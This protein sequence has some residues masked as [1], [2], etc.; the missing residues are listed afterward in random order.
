MFYLSLRPFPCAR[1]VCGTRTSRKLFGGTTVSFNVF[2]CAGRKNRRGSCGE[3]RERQLGEL[4]EDDGSYVTISAMKEKPVPTKHTQP[5][6]GEA[7]KE[8][9]RERPRSRGAR[10]GS[11]SGRSSSATRRTFD[12][13][14]EKARRCGAGTWA[15]GL[16]PKNR[17]LGQKPP[18]SA[19][20]QRYR[21]GCLSSTDHD[22]PRLSSGIG[23]PQRQVPC[24]VRM[25]SGVRVPA[26]AL[27]KT[28][29]QTFGA[30]FL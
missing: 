23:G 26:S 8:D 20:L 10:R 11:G 7:S 29:R 28:C 1:S 12:E 17:D 6:R 18:G 3:V 27:T 30:R 15:M 24:M 25:G 21:Q 5:P 16:D 13:L 2:R 9:G 22:Q 19:R 4:A 14:A